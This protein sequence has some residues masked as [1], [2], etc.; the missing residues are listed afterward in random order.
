MTKEIKTEIQIKATAETVWNILMDFGNYPNWNPFIKRLE[1]SGKEGQKLTTTLQAPGSNPMVFK[2]IV[3]K[4]ESKRRFS[5]LGHLF[6]PG[7]FDGEHIF[8]LF[9]QGNGTVVFIQREKFNGILV[10][11]FKKMLD[12]PTTEGFNLM[13]QKL[14]ELAE[15]PGL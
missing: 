1:G 9:D 6:F 12:G 7:L 13:N 14:K 3:L 15:S 8:E 11:L 4:N 5:W 2:P 10:P